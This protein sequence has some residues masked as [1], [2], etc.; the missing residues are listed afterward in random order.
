M[1]NTAFSQEGTMNRLGTAA[2]SAMILTV[3]ARAAQLTAEEAAQH[4]GE[5]ATVCGVVASANYAQRKRSQP[6][7]LDIGGSIK[8]VLSIPDHPATR[9]RGA[10]HSADISNAAAL[11]VTSPARARLPGDA[12]QDAPNARS[13][14]REPIG[15]GALR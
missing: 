4:V 12:D 14:G 2:A 9:P 8:P 5:Q 10:G 6:T 11:H 7:F 13:V 3:T 15:A 1:L